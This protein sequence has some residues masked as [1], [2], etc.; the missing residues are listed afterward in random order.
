M[1]KIL[2]QINAV[3][4]NEKNLSDFILS[5]IGT[6]ADKTIRDTL[7]NLV[8]FKKGKN[9]SGKKIGVFAHMDEV[10]LI[11]KNITDEGYIKFSSVG[12]ID[13]RIL[14]GQKVL[15]GENT[16]GIIG[17]KAIHLQSKGE[18]DKVI[19]MDELCIDIGAKDKEDALK[20]VQKGDYISF[21]SPYENLYGFRFKSKAIDDRA[22][23]AII[24][25]LIK[26]EYEEDIYFCFTVQEEVG[27]RGA[28]VLSR[29]LDLDVGII[30]EATTC[31][32]T[33]YMPKHLRSTRLGEGVAISL[34]DNASYADKK[35]NAFIKDIADTKGI[36]YQYKLT[37]NGGNDAREIQTGASGCK[38]TTLSLPARYIHSPNTVFDYR[39]F[40]SMKKLAKQ[41]LLEIKKFQ[42]S[43]EI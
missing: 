11:L 38:V 30:L 25:D 3:S 15:I 29:R 14:I 39:D 5:Q 20:Y 23:C 1:M 31:Q 21:I 10:G 19:K 37:S 43:E 27:L 4:G 33:A 6:Y 42:I 40:E 24:M 34:M 8:F 13:E 9:P 7:G 18:T 26:D 36:K 35:L 2:T 28:S 22:G 16:I 32:D 41:T 17:I 12:G